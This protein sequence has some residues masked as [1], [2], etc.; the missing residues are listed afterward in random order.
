MAKNNIIN[1]DLTD[2]FGLDVS[3]LSAQ[4]QE[5]ILVTDSGSVVSSLSAMTDGQI[6]I[7]STGSSPV[8]A[9]LTAGSGISIVNAPG[10][11]TVSYTG[12]GTL[13]KNI[14]FLTT[15][16]TYTPTAGTVS[17][18]IIAVG[19]G[20][21]GSGVRG[22]AGN[23]VADGGSGGAACYKYYATAPSDVEYTIGTGGAGGVGLLAA[24]NGTDTIFNGEV[25]AG[26]GLRGVQRIGI[27]SNYN[28]SITGNVI[29][30][31][32][33]GA[34]DTSD[35]FYDGGSS[36]PFLIS[37]PIFNRS[38]SGG[39]GGNGMGS[40]PT[41]SQTSNNADGFSAT[42]PGGGGGG[43][44]GTLN[45]TRTGGS[46]ADGIIIVYEYGV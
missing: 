17:C 45:Q 28:L 16:G 30:G 44:N 40:A 42:T 21:G 4:D 10:S 12:G 25:V 6:A 27:E 3:G 20:G 26:G 5:R 37:A 24:S 7:G 15:S 8:A 46:G 1:N 32:T 29:S 34:S 2:C 13:L 11:I 39:G 19:G 41:R 31:G 38:V 35:Y 9:T 14:R 33:A 23:N 43:A 18:Q 22:S 36:V